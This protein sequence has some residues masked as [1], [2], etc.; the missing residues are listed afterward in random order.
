[1]ILV[2]LAVTAAAVY[3]GRGLV[4]GLLG[5]GCGTEGGCAKCSSGA[6][7]TLTKLEAIRKDYEAKKSGQTLS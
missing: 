6:G 3:F 7:C 5:R 4:L 2:L 1:M